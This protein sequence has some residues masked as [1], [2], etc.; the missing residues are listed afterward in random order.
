MTHLLKR[1]ERALDEARRAGAEAAEVF[2]QTIRSISVGVEKNDVQISRSQQETMIGI[3]AFVGP[4]VGFA[5]TNDPDQLAAAGADAVTLAK[6]SPPDEHNR[7]PDAAPFAPVEG[8]FDPAAE[9]FGVSDAVRRATEILSIAE[10]IDRRVILGEGQFVAEVGERIVVNTDGLSAGE[11]ASLF[12]YFV[13]AT[14]QDGEAVSN[15]DFQF[16]ASRSVAGIEIAPIVERACRNALGSLGATKGESFVG[17]VILSPHAVQSILV[18]LL[19]FQLNAKNVLRGMSRWRDAIGKTVAVPSLVVSDDGRRPGGVATSSFDREGT[20]H[21]PMTVIENGV[22]RGFLHNAYTSRAMGQPNTGHASGSARSLPTIGPT[23]FSIAPG[24][25]PLEEMIGEVDRGIL[26]TRFSGTAD[27]VSGDFS[28]VAKAAHRIVHG[29]ID[30]PVTETLIAGN[31][32]EALRSLSAI[33]AERESIFAFTLPYVRL[34]GISVT[35][36]E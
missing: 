6:A 8:T 12:S 34:D 15:M 11:R 20:P 19:L 13:V 14:A 33:S 9:Q 4:R 30:R 29:R 16:G 21:R 32:F 17:S 10:G 36:G 5:C 2:G 18:Q 1:C 31:S 7:L 28:G 22:L 23:N 26:V 24:E 25:R 3:R 27:P 35:G